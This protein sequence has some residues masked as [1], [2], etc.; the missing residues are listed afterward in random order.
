M[1]EI[2][3]RIN[4][5]F[6]GGGEWPS[7]IVD[8]SPD[9]FAPSKVYDIK[10]E[11]DTELSAEYHEQI[12]GLVPS[13]NFYQDLDVLI[14]ANRVRNHETQMYHALKHMP[15]DSVIAYEKALGPRHHQHETF[16]ELNKDEDAP[17]TIPTLHYQKKPAAL[18]AEEVIDKYD[19]DSIES[20]KV[21]AKEQRMDRGW[22]LSP[23]EGGSVVDFGIHAAELPIVNFGG[24]FADEPLVNAFGW[25]TQTDIKNDIVA[26]YNEAFEAKWNIEGDL[27]REDGAE[28]K[29]FVGKGFEEDQKQFLI[30]GNDDNLG[31]WKIRGFYGTEENDPFL[32]FS[33]GD[34]YND[35]D[36]SDRPNAKEAVIDELIAYLEDGNEP[37]LDPATHTE[38]TRG[39]D[40]ANEEIGLNQD[41]ELKV[42]KWRGTPMFDYGHLELNS[43]F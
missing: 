22:T 32:E 36:L 26:R 9:E 19:L 33:N 27:F 7:K 41:E 35:W 24:R 5:G 1:G 2:E 17:F 15:E 30:E 25:N 12:E 34:M 42:E 18:K 14:L 13:E 23:P 4:V 16:M 6:A 31:D 21:V 38:L 11:E 20:I 40:A 29:A 8:H 28:L 10:S 39:L 37:R 3:D 43:Y